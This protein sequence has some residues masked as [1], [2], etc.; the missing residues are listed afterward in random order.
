MQSTET[1]LTHLRDARKA[2]EAWLQ[3]EGVPAIEVQVEADDHVT[4]PLLRSSFTA[5]GSVDGEGVFEALCLAD[6]KV[7]D[8]DA[9]VITVG[10]SRKRTESLFRQIC[11]EAVTALPDDLPKGCQCLYWSICLP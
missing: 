2:V 1:V 3:R 7:W 11:S 5:R 8:Y 9:S 4:V 6:L 10:K